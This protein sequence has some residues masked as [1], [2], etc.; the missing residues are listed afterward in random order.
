MNFYDNYNNLF[1]QIKYVKYKKNMKNRQ[2]DE[3]NY[4]KKGQKDDIIRIN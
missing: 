1:V 3:N 4:S 2:K